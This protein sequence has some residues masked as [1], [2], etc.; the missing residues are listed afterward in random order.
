M[1]RTT[2]ERIATPVRL[3]L[4]TDCSIRGIG[5]VAERMRDL[6]AA[7]QPAEIDCANIEAA[8]IALVQLIISARRSFAARRLPLTIEGASAAVRSAFARASVSLA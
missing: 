3:S 8:D 1:P 4:P 7:G 2:P 6:L 5:A